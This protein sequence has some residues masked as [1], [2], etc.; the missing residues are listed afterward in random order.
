[1][2]RGVRPRERWEEGPDCQGTLW[3]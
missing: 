3:R 1:M 2:W